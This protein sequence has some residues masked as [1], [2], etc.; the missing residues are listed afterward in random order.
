MKAGIVL[1]RLHKIGHQRVFEQHGHRAVGFDVLGGD[2]LA[3]ARLADDDVAEPAL[4][5]PSRSIARQKIA[6]TSE[7]TVMSKPSSRGKPLA[8]PP[9]ELTIERS[10]RSFMSTTR[11]QVTRRGVDAELIAPIDVVVDHRRAAGCWRR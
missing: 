1:Q 10:A 4:A 9:S 11:R 2:R 3:V 7:A 6:I 8:T 5:D